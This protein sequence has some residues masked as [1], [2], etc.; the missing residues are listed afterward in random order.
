MHELEGVNKYLRML[1]VYIQIDNRN[2]NY[3]WNFV[4]IVRCIG[5]TMFQHKTSYKIT[6]VSPAGK[7]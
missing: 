3:Y 6:L 4:A 7:T 5:G 1:L 2:D